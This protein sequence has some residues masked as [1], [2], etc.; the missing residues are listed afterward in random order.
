MG[1]EK[2]WTLPRIRQAYIT[3]KLNYKQLCEKYG[4]PYSTLSKVAQNEKWHES[5]K[6]YREEVAKKALLRAQARDVDHLAALREGADSLAGT[7][8][9]VLGSE[10]QLYTWAGVLREAD[11][12]EYFQ[13]MQL[14]TID[15]KKLKDLADALKSLTSTIR[16]LYNL[17]TQAE[18][19]AQEIALRRI[20]LEEKRAQAEE[21]DKK[22]EIIMDEASEEASG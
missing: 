14:G 16:N 15:T 17:P 20:Q 18:S 13:E 4:V 3:G 19:T 5:R 6:N 8:K 7:V 10:E 2:K 12:S 11:G 9:A 21:P 22:I 1:R